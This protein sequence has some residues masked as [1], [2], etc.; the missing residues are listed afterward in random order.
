MQIQ[1]I[2]KKTYPKINSSLDA[3]ILLAKIL[4]KSR[5][6]ILSHGEKK[7]TSKKIADYKKLIN[8]RIKNIPL[9]YLLGEKE[10]YGLNFLVN[11]NVLIPR[12]ETEILVEQ[13]LEIVLNNTNKNNYIIDIGTGSGCIIIT[14]IKELQKKISY[15]KLQKYSFFAS[16]ISKKALQVARQNTRQHKLQKKINFLQGSLLEP[17]LEKQNTKKN[18]LTKSQNILILANLPYLTPQ[19]VKDSPTIQ[20]EPEL[21]LVAG[22][23]GLK[24]YQQLFKEIKKLKKLNFS[25]QMICEIDPAQVSFLKKIVKQELGKNIKIIKDLRKKNR[26]VYVG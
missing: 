7:I 6:F 20:A 21:A 16:D 5:E 15:Q 3:E 1:E 14:F 22:R 10:F 11:K 19:Q 24:Y 17:F 9:A 12:P 2:L 13:A 18:K 23:D 26:F 8:K 25:Y 4:K